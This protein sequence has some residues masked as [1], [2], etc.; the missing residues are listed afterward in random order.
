MARKIGGLNIEMSPENIEG[1]QQYFTAHNL[2]TR[3]IKNFAI[4]L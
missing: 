4:Y 2:Y 1:E 3:K